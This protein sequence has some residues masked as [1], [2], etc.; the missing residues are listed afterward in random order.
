MEGD[1]DQGLHLQQ[2]WLLM[3]RLMNTRSWQHHTK[4]EMR[5]GATFSF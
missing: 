1:D 2:A 3:D 4:V 5:M